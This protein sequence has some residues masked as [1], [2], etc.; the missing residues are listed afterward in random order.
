MGI[1]VASRV[2][3]APIWKEY[4]Q[5]GIKIISTWIDEA[6]DGE[7]G[8]FGELWA[9]IKREITHSQALVFYAQG[10]EDFPFKGALV[11]VG[12]A[13]ALNKP[14]F[15]CINDVQ[16]EGRTL[17]PL[18]SWSLADQVTM[19]KTLDEAINLASAA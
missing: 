17:R 2:S 16:L 12:M 6:G 15:V 5:K 3:R 11:E 14:V 8:D 19:C 18:G 7:T 10:L 13:L 9:R 1:Y 4:R